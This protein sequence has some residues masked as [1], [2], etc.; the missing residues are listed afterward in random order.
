MR[1]LLED[2]K[3]GELVSAE[4]VQRKETSRNK[5]KE[6]RKTKKPKAKEVSFFHLEQMIC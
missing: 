2:R 4:D 5:K 6:L 3:N 1:I